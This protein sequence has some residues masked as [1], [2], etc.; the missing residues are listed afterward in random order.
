[1]KT[2]EDRRRKRRKEKNK[3]FAKKRGDSITFALFTE[4]AVHGLL[5]HDGTVPFRNRDSFQEPLGCEGIRPVTVRREL[6]LWS[7][8]KTNFYRRIGHPNRICIVS[9]LVFFVYQNQMYHPKSMHLWWHDDIWWQQR[10]QASVS[11]HSSQ[12]GGGVVTCNVSAQVAL[13]TV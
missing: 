5:L 6:L 3:T 13:G 1:M 9:V 11:Q 10:R 8:E 12:L 7:K 2:D 4:I